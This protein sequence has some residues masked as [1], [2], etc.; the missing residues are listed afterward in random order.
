MEKDKC[1][2]LAS[3]MSGSYTAAGMMID[4]QYHHE[5]SPRKDYR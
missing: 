2:A 3:I 5:L 4:R 1:K